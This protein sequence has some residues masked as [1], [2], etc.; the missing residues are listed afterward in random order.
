MSRDTCKA[1]LGV[2]EGVGLGYGDPDNPTE[3]V[4]NCVSCYGSGFQMPRTPADA[5]R[6]AGAM[7]AAVA[8]V[9]GPE[10]CD[11]SDCEECCDHHELDHFVCMDCGKDLTEQKMSDAYDRAKDIRKYGE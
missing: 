5:R 11:A 7:K 1:C 8:A 2:S 4:G 10:P 9:H 6:L 3:E